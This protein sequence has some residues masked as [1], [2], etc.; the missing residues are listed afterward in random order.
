M[1][2]LRKKKYNSER[3]EMILS[4]SFLNKIKMEDAVEI[5]SIKKLK[6]EVN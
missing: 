6:K 3:K 5:K 1:L 2:I 4:N